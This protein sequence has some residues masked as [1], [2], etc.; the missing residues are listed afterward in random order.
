[1]LNRKTLAVCI[2]TFLFIIQG[3][4]LPKEKITS[5]VNP[6]IGTGGHGHT[7]PGA[8]LPFGMVQLS[9]DTYNR[10]WDWSSGY[11]I[12]DNSIMGF[13]HTHLSGT[14]IG[15]LG[16]ILI[17][18]TTGAVKTEPGNREKPGEGYRSR[19]KHENEKAYPGYYSVLL[20]DYNIKAELTATRRTGYHRYTFPKT[21]EANIIIDL[22]HG[23]EDR[24]GNSQIK[25]ISDSEIEGYRQSSGWAGNNQNIYFVAK[26]SKPFKSHGIVL[27]GKM[28]PEEKS[29]TGIALKGYVRFSTN[30]N[31]AIL[32]KVGISYVSIDGARKN[33]EAE[34]KNAGFDEI[35]T[36]AEKIWEKELSKITVEGGSQDQKTIFYTALYHSM[37]CPNLFSDIDGNYK[38]MDD[39][40]IH[41]NKKNETYTLFS[42]WDTFRAL[43]PLLSIIDRK[44]TNDFINTMLEK[45]QEGGQLPVW[46]CMGHET[47][48][49]IGFHSISVIVD[50]YMK[51]IK[52]YDVEKVYE[53][54]KRQLEQSKAG[55][56]YYNSLGYIPAEKMT[57]SVSRNLE[58]T[59]NEW[60][61]AKMAEALGKKED[62]EKYSKR[63]L[64]YMNMF[65][66]STGFMRGKTTEGNFV[67]PFTPDKVTHDYE[68]GTAWHYNLFVPHD[69]NG[70]VNMFGNIENFSKRLNDLFTLQNKETSDIPDV[71]GIIG[72]YAHGNEPSH[73]MAYLFNFNGE[74]WKTQETVR[75]IMNELYFPKPDGL[76]GNEDCGQ[77][78]AWYVF[79]AMGF[80]PFC[81]GTNQYMIGSPIFNKITINLENGKHFVINAPKSSNENKYI[82]SITKNNKAYSL[83]YIKHE[84]ISK[85]GSF[86]FNMSN[87]PA[88][89]VK[90]AVDALPYSFTKKAQ[91]SVPYNKSDETVFL[92]SLS[93]SFG[94][95]TNGADIYFSLDGSIPTKASVKYNEPISVFE[96]KS[97]TAI[98]FKNGFEPS[99]FAKISTQ[100][101]KLYESKNIDNLAPGLNY[102]YYEGN[103]NSVNEMKK[104]AVKKSGV[105]EL[106]VITSAEKEENFGF[107]FDGFIN[108]SKEGMYKFYTRSDDGSVLIIDDQIVVNNDGPHSATMIAGSIA[109]KAGFHSIK[110][111]YCQG[112][113]DAE[114]SAGL[115]GPG[116]K[117]QPIQKEWLFRIK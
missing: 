29:A 50:A 83:T 96:S 99:P 81:P 106:P 66:P 113:G 8:T 3:V 37:I 18:P 62:Y 56:N 85:G 112:A 69:I 115:E 100:K 38:G 102:Q 43:N 59:Y 22:F 70:L 73:N 103:Y 74:N 2:M 86:T 13:S 23:I 52:D 105:A 76:S 42:L 77:M 54:M 94:C 44:R 98:A 35:K 46:E 27:D 28:K 33:L 71:T 36:A 45:S 101:A 107:I 91:V 80:Y 10:G 72:Q 14:G 6:F 39:N 5:N 84:D 31:E 104:S 93:I 57:K 108:I 51:G 24:P 60:C 109:L 1:M 117:L 34:L 49:M 68:E 48:I 47:N 88:K 9:P 30:N 82:K 79:S 12:T 26:F 116:I 32:V 16:D 40:K 21:D 114:F 41:N 87:V 55:L 64:N 90:Y 97:I 7:F 15:D 20:D 63:A 89:D 110:M 111:L 75:K 67:T 19:F 92:D 53:A 95:L 25:F 17:M 11:Y 65:D 78:S 4:S 61:V 58:Y